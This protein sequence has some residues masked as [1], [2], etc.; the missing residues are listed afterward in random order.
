M[1]LNMSALYKTHY[2]YKEYITM[3]KNAFTLFTEKDIRKHDALGVHE[4]TLILSY[5]KLNKVV[6]F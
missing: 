2:N 4:H 5:Y 6:S 3:Y 1:Q